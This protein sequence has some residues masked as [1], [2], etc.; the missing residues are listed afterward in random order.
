MPPR[1]WVRAPR[2]LTAAQ[3]K[4]AHRTAYMLAAVA[5]DPRSTDLERYN[6]VGYL[7]DM[8]AGYVPP[9]FFGKSGPKK[10]RRRKASRKARRAR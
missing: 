7:Y 5:D 3:R 8:R 4:K 10:K 9:R 6:A 1:G 2:K